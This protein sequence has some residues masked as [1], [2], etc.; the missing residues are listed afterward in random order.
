[1]NDTN[2]ERLKM[3]L[4]SYFNSLRYLT[5][6]SRVVLS[7]SLFLISSL[8]VTTTHGYLSSRSIARTTVITTTTTTTFL[9]KSTTGRRIT[10]TQRRLFPSM[11]LSISS[12]ETSPCNYN[13]VFVAGGSKGVGHAIVQKL[14]K[15]GGI[16]V[17]A[18]VRS[19]D[20]KKELDQ[21]IG[22]TAVLGDAL[23]KKKVED[24]M[25]GCD[26]AITTL[27]GTT[28]DRQVDYEGNSNVIE[29]VGK[30]GVE[31]II[32]VTSIGCGSSKEAT[33][34]NILEVLKN[35][36]EAKEKAE[37]K[38]MDL[39]TTST[40]DPKN[41]SIIR[42]GGLVSEPM[43]GQAILTEDTTV[44]GSI[45]REDVADLVI[46]VLYSTKTEGK[47]LSAVDPSIASSV[48]SES[49]A[50]PVFEM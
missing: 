45:H 31:R 3:E 44:I 12:S 13:K 43:T 7:F 18:L 24:A 20:S 30:L 5:I 25:D 41:W 21:M 36:L 29:S 28:D 35:V 2:E 16:E 47:V 17:V 14:S 9:N 19:E 37:N 8:I 27:G 50:I 49:K 26:A 22:V 6:R 1:M 11:S 39:G 4:I 33:P 23:D 46:K 40:D 10:N 15:L 48:A 38:L 42:P 34:P 32:L